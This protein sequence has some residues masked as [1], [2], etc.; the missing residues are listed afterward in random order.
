MGIKD[1][2]DRAKEAAG[3]AQSF[4]TASI[5]H[6]RGGLSTLTEKQKKER[7]DICEKC[8]FI[9]NS[10]PDNPRCQKCS[11]FLVIKVGWPAE[12]CP[13]GKWKETESE[14][15]KSWKYPKRGC[16]GCRRG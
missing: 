7:M 9:N 16:G 11:C 10:N 5:K 15:P 13:I 3:M 2:Y 1:I 14:R 8:E 12:E 6:I 4:A